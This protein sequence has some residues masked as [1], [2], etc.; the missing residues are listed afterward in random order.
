MPLCVLRCVSSSNA[1][2]IFRSVRWQRTD[3]KQ[4]KLDPDLIVL[5]RSMPVMSGPDA[6]R[7]LRG[8]VPEAVLIMYCA[9]PEECSEAVLKSLGISAIVSKSESA[10]VLIDTC[11]SLLYGKAAHSLPPSRGN[12]MRYYPSEQLRFELQQ[13]LCKQREVL[14]SRMFGTATDDD[15][16]EYEVRQDIIHELCNVLANWTTA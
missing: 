5:D 15:L 14:E 9:T 7:A 8:V 16:I 4:L 11:R 2:R 3:G 12:I 1:R 10:S 13:L 6:A